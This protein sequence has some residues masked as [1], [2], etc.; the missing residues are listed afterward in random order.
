MILNVDGSINL[1]TTGTA[2]TTQKLVVSDTTESTGLGNGSLTVS[3][4]VS[5][6]KSLFVGSNVGV[7]GSFSAGVSLTQTITTSNLVNANFANYNNVKTIINSNEVFLSCVFTVSVVATN[8]KTS[9]IISLPFKTTSFSSVSDIVITSSGMYNDGTGDYNDIQNLRCYPN[10]S[11]ANVKVVMTSGNL[12]QPHIIYFM[13]RY[14][15]N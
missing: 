7:T 9:F 6:A 14:T 4:G 11:S 10:G 3:G 12:S 2:L 13:A 1:N 15:A 8:A 5:I